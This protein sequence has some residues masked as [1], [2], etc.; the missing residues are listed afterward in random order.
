MRLWL[1]V[2]FKLLKRLPGH[3]ELSSPLLP[4]PAPF[5][6]A[7]AQLTP[8][9]WFQAG[10]EG[11]KGW[12]NSVVTE[13]LQERPPPPTLLPVQEPSGVPVT[14]SPSGSSPIQDNVW[15]HLMF[16]YHQWEKFK[17][18]A[19]SRSTR[20]LALGALLMGALWLDPGRRGCR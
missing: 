14:S 15:I 19:P 9:E 4:F 3:A 8:Q 11:A 18:S 17:S 6:L 2:C 12:K 7:G 20:Q 1:E 10:A 13:Q 16:L 5:L